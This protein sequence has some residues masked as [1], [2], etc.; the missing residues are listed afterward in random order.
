MIVFITLWGP[1]DVKWLF[2]VSPITVVSSFLSD[3]NAKK[4]LKHAERYSYT[5]TECNK[6]T[7]GYINV[8]EGVVKMH[9]WSSVTIT[10]IDR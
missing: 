3:D 6:H 2:G 8:T 10:Q 1:V 5:P 4:M 7:F 9:V